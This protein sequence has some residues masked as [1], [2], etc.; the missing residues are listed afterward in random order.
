VTNKQENKQTNKLLLTC[1]D[2]CPNENSLLNCCAATTTN[3]Y[4]ATTHCE[5]FLEKIINNTFLYPF[6]I[7]VKK[8]IFLWFSVFET[9]LFLVG[10]SM[11]VLSH[12][13]ISLNRPLV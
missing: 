8:N 9:I 3:I 13:T 10:H 6:K 7:F 11:D 1:I 5:K 4:F 12:E 2:D